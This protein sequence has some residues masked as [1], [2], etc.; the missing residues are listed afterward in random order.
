MKE[1]EGAGE[2]LGSFWKQNVQ[3]IGDQLDVGDEGSDE[4]GVGLDPWLQGHGHQRPGRK[5]EQGWV[6][7]Q[8]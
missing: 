6:K 3:V 4:V 1:H 5:K 2:H 7:R 8:V